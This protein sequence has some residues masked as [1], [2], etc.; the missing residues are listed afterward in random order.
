MV[1]VIIAYGLQESSI[2]AQKY[3]EAEFNM[4]ACAF[5]IHVVVNICADERSGLLGGEV[6]TV[7]TSH[8][9]LN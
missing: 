1:S 5:C 9:L 7:C 4:H 2:Q 8:Q 3:S 6:V